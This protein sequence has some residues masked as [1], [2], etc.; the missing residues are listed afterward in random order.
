M[1]WPNRLRFKARARVRA[2]VTDV[3][4]QL[5]RQF[6]LMK[7]YILDSSTT[8]QKKLR[9]FLKALSTAVVSI[10]QEVDCNFPTMRRYAFKKIIQYLYRPLEA[11]IAT[12]QLLYL[13]KMASTTMLLAI[14]FAALREQVERSK[15]DY[16]D[17][18]DV[19]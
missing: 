3:S 14:D 6:E 17:L 10:R 16:D 12:L 2:F 1:M 8:K 15:Y 11:S 13:E 19:V 7:L 4:H 5:L 9:E 18:A